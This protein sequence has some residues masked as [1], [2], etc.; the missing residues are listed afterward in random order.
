[1]PSKL[2]DNTGGAQAPLLQ[3]PAFTGAER[4][5]PRSGTVARDASPAGAL[6]KL[7][8]FADTFESVDPDTGEV[9]TLERVK[10]RDGHLEVRRAYDQDA[11]DLERWAL[12]QHARRLLMRVEDRDRR[13]RIP[14]TEIALAS[15]VETRRLFSVP[16]RERYYVEPDPV[17][18]YCR[19]S[20]RKL[21]EAE[22][23]KAVRFRVVNCLRDKIGAST[24]PEIWYSRQTQRASFHNVG[25]CGSVW[26]CPICSRRINLKR[27]AH[28]RAAYDLFITAK[29]LIKPGIHAADA[30]MVTFTVRH[31]IGD[32]LEDL[33]SKL[34][35]ADRRFL[36]KAY[37]YKRIV[38]Y[39]RT[40]NKQRVQV[41]S[42]YAYI[43]RVSTTE[44][45][46]G[47]NG[48]HPHLHQLWFFDRRLEAGEIERI[49][50]DLFSEW[51]KACESVGLPAPLEYD[52]RGHAVGVDVRRALSADEYL[53]KFGH[54][55]DWGPEKEMASQHV[56]KSTG[57]RTPFQ[58][59]YEYGQGDKLAGKLFADF[60][61]ATLGRH[62]VEFSKGLKA[63]LVELGL[64]EV[65]VADEELAAQLETESDR[66]GELTDDDFE[67]LQGAERFNIE[68]FG[69]LL[70]LCKSVG[71]DQAID[72]L[73]SLPSFV[74]HEGRRRSV[75]RRQECEDKWAAASMKSER[76]FWS[77][78]NQ[79]E[80]RSLTIELEDQASLLLFEQSPSVRA[81]E[82]K[83]LADR[84]L[85]AWMSD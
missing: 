57:G 68:A 56:K 49:R 84:A 22:Q 75:S 36:Q 29:P 46:H 74:D 30:M 12:K 72:W 33:L 34:K 58:L 14:Y 21:I 45:T 47:K 50:A 73:R 69:T 13:R 26:T 15:N 23:K 35:E 8:K 25:V 42:P 76:E 52:R 37:A 24:Q 55:R 51:A 3:Q 63:R 70:A 81:K 19:I 54:E 66:L 61:E 43:G 71:F 28:I 31:G 18:P 4:R 65:L 67:A 17:A 59:L 44:L 16:V 11:S 80:N 39:K 53:T 9:L 83:G 1:M 60:A 82:W 27:Q 85:R 2:A 78:I 41:V 6:G 10:S 38:G 62:Q 40:I 48:W 32:D 5:P 20:D 64:E 77:W 79:C 7:T